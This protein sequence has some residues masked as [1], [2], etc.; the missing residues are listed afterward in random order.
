MLGRPATKIELN[1]DSDLEELIEIRK[2]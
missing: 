1:R 2:I